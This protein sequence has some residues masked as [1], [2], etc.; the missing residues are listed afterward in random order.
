[1]QTGS[2]LTAGHAAFLALLA[3]LALATPIQA[4]D[5]TAQ[6]LIIGGEPV[7]SDDDVPSWLANYRLVLPDDSI[8]QPVCAATLVA[9][10]WAMTAA[11]CIFFLRSRSGQLFP[12]PPRDIYVQFDQADFDDDRSYPNSAGAFAERVVLH[13]N[14]SDTNTQFDS[15]IALLKLAGEAG[16]NRTAVNLPVQ[17]PDA[18]DPLSLLGWGLT[19]NPDDDPDRESV[20]QR[21]D[22]HPVVGR[23]ECADF[24]ASGVITENMICAGVLDPEED[25]QSPCFGDSG[26]PLFDETHGFSEQFGIVSFGTG[27]CGEQPRDDVRVPSVYTNM[28]VFGPWVATTVGSEPAGPLN[29]AIDGETEVTVSACDAFKITLTFDADSLRERIFDPRYFSDVGLNVNSLDIDLTNGSIDLTLTPVDESER[30]ELT[31]VVFD[32][33]LN[34][35][36]AVLGLTVEGS[37]CTGNEESPDVEADPGSMDDL[38]PGAPAAPTPGSSSSSS[39]GGGGGALSW[40]WAMLLLLGLTDW[41]RRRSSRSR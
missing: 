7:D 24:Y 1:M 13:P 37:Q 38:V 18:G 23:D 29:L 41:L 15:D 3:S 12:M 4:D 21:L 6:P 28:E 36:D 19:E 40:P 25:N 31:F 20:L 11:H 39:S 22:D 33:Y 2:G 17:E 32:E 34:I 16:D 14:Y 8:S 26:G 30:F 10:G 27:R 5:T 35:Q 9:E